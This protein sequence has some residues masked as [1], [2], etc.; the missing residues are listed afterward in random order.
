[1]LNIFNNY[2]RQDDMYIMQERF[3]LYE[4]FK[5]ILLN[6]FQSRE[7]TFKKRFEVLN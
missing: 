2:W 3:L 1:M 5:K 6:N 7:I 4:L